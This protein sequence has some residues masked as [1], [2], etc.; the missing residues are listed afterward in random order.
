MLND[1]NIKEY[2]Q[3]AIYYVVSRHLP[4]HYDALRTS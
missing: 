1:F 2:V 3:L 4:M